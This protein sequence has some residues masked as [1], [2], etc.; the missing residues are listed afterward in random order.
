M[1]KKFL[2]ELRRRLRTLPK[3]ERERTVSYFEELID[4]AVEEGKTEE[5]AV[6]DLGNP[7][8]IA[9]DILGEANIPKK[10]K[11]SAGTIV[12][13]V[14]GSPIWL[15]LLVAAVCIVFSVVIALYSIVLAILVTAVALVV[16]GVAT[17]GYTV[18]YYIWQY[19]T[20]SSV[21]IL[22]GS[23]VAI[24]LDLLLFPLGILAGKKLT[25][26]CRYCFHRCKDWRRG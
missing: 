6:A 11:L 24:G 12:L 18:C 3:E 21:L 15:S 25:Q 4:D 10:K 13:L 7:A 14:V 19:P 5:A 22:G 17:F 8:E 16:S 2:K 26:L 1:K 9:A 20:A 23:L